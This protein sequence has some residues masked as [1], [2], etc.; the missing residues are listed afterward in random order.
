MEITKDTKVA[1]ILTRYGDI[2]DVMEA[3]GVKRI[4]RFS[5]RK[6][7]TKLITVERAARIHRIPLDELLDKL[8][9]AVAIR[10][11]D[12]SAKEPRP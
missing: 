6:V 1:D 5:I 11:A 3:L 7:I 12:H 9:T 10:E 2:A 8:R 4:G